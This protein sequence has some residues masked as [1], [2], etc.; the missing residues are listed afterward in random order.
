MVFEEKA[1][2]EYVMVSNQDNDRIGA[3]QQMFQ[4]LRDLQQQGVQ[5][6]LDIKN[7]WFES[8][9]PPYPPWQKAIVRHTSI[10]SEFR[11]TSRSITWLC[12]GRT[13]V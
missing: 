13:G 6:T 8:F 11:S 4:N 12:V 7:V 9:V 3:F 5:S 1:S 2:H 10:S